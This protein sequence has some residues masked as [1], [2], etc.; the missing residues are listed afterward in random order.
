MYSDSMLHSYS[1]KSGQKLIYYVNLHLKTFV[2][3]TYMDPH[4]ITKIL[5]LHLMTKNDSMES[6][7]EIN[8]KVVF[9]LNIGPCIKI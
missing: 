9:E 5:S 7:F 1:V 8:P 2:W 4:I 3:G 6:G